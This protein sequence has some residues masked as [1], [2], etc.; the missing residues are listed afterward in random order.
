M[1][2]VLFLINRFFISVYL[3]N[4]GIQN[5]NKNKSITIVIVE[6]LISS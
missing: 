6:S 3:D 5:S 2:I 1:M 4:A